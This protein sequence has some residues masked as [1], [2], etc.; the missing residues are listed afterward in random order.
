VSKALKAEL[1]LGK[2]FLGIT[3]SL[4][5]LESANSAIHIYFLCYVTEGQSSENHRKIRHSEFSKSNQILHEH[6]IDISQTEGGM[7]LDRGYVIVTLQFVL[8]R[9]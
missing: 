7:P 4:D 1:P 3:S 2:C 6:L 8:L 5:G 9:C